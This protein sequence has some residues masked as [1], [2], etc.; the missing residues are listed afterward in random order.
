MGI[1][2]LK[3]SQPVLFPQ[4]APP[5]TA[6]NSSSTAVASSV[7]NNEKLTYRKVAKQTIM[8]RLHHSSEAP[9]KHQRLQLHLCCVVPT[10]LSHYAHN[11]GCGAT[12]ARAAWQGLSY[13]TAEP[14]FQSRP[15]PKFHPHVP[16]FCLCAFPSLLYFSKLSTTTSNLSLNY[17]SPETFSMIL[18]HA[19][20]GYVRNNSNLL[21]YFTFKM[22]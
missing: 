14:P 18:N 20:H 5:S 12:I 22:T 11:L 21:P 8:R 15:A 7:R 10:Y 19:P 16:R 9:H 3:I 13:G 6:L 4:R 2:H 17:Y 1:A